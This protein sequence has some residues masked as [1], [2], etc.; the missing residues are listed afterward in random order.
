MTCRSEESKSII[1]VVG[2]TVQKVGARQACHVCGP[3]IPWVLS[4][5]KNLVKVAR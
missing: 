4:V 5:G 2:Y 3:A 1:L